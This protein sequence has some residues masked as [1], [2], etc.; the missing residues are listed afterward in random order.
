MIMDTFRRLKNLLALFFHLFLI[1]Y[2]MGNKPEY[3]LSSI[4]KVIIFLKKKDY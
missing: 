2:C 1:I 3:V 4:Y